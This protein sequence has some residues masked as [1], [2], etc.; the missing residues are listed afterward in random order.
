MNQRMLQ[1][2]KTG[3]EE[4]VQYENLDSFST[5]FQPCE[6]LSNVKRRVGNGS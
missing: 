6:N 5:L 1:W 2:F 4:V 3:T